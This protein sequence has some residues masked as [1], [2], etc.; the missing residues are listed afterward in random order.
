MIGQMILIGFPGT[1]PQEE[2]PAR[3]VKMIHDS[4]IGGVVLFSYNVVDPAQVKALNAA[5]RDAGATR[6]PFVCVDQ[7]GGSIQRLTRAKGFIGLPGASKISAMGLETAYKLDVQAAHELANLG[8]NV[9]FGPVVDL[10]I[11]PNNPAIGRLGRSYGA[12]PQKVTD[13]ARQFI[14]AHAQANVLTALKHF[15][16]HGSAGNDPHVDIVDI[17]KTWKKEELLPYQNLISGISGGSVDMVMVGHLIQ[18]EFSDTGDT[19]ASLAPASLSRRAIVDQLRSKLGFSGLVITDDL[20]MGAIRNRYSVEQAAVMAVAAG[21]DLIIIANHKQPD[22]AIADRIIAA[23][24]QAVKDKR[25]S[26][27]QIH[28]AY[29]LIVNAK[30][31]LSDRRAYVME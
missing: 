25:I 14:N 23:V 21:A 31:K 4:R 5:F 13:Y 22:P 2:W 12:D 3:V 24:S 9:N 16:G 30:I 11:N 7:E 20:D 18:P 28:Q 6:R 1:K 8:F 15:P 19:P 17:S 10:N 27:E 26:A 29:R